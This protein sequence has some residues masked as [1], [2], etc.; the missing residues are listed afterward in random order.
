MFE[1]FTERAKKVMDCANEE[2]HRLC[3]EF[4]G[5]EHILLGL[6]KEGTGVGASVL[7]QMGITAEAVRKAVEIKS[8]KGTPKTLAGKLPS[9]PRTKKVIEF[10]INEARELG[11]N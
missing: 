3:H 2:A 11:H 9:S 5:T 1:K 10:A 7:G 8:G 4:I 6:V